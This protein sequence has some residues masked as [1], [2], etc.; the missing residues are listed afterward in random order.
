MN[1]P[2]RHAISMRELQKM[3]A[4]Q[5]Q[6]LK[7]AVPITSD[8]RTVAILSPLRTATPAELERLAQSRQ[9][10]DESLTEDEKQRIAKL[11]D[12]IESS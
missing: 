4:R 7:H 1:A 12:E 5:I 11:L 9:R 8:G 6:D 10:F 3:S 2:F